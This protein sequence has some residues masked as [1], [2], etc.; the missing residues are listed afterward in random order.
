MNIVGTISNGFKGLSSILAGQSDWRDAYSFDAHGFNVAFLLYAIAALTSLVAL[1]ARIGFPAP[2]TTI[3]LVAG[4]AL[5]VLALIFSSSFA[6]RVSGVSGP[7]T[8]FYVPGFYVL[9]LMGFIGAVTIMAG[10]PLWGAVM[11]VTAVLLFKLAR[12]IGLEFAPALAFGLFNF[13]AGLPYALYMMN[14]SFA[15]AP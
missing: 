6:R 12:A 2:S 9:A 10:F 15:V 4:L 1:G 13:V 11:A 7:V 5:P 14:G 3:T 8:E